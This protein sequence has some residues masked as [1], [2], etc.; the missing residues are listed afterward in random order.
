MG[1]KCIRRH[2]RWIYHTFRVDGTNPPSGTQK[3]LLSVFL[4]GGPC[5]PPTLGMIL[6]PC[7]LPFDTGDGKQGHW[8]LETLM[9]SLVAP[10]PGAVLPSSVRHQQTSTDPILQNK[11]GTGWKTHFPPETGDSKDSF[12][13]FQDHILECG[14]DL[15][16]WPGRSNMVLYSRATAQLARTPMEVGDAIGSVQEQSPYPIF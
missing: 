9:V 8:H 7:S 1:K 12:R 2:P 13:T 14:G 10:F 16:R 15:V 3:G 5:K 4:C 11:N 6:D